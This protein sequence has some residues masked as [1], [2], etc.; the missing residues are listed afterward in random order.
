MKISYG[1]FFLGKNSFIKKSEKSH[2]KRGFSPAFREYSVSVVWKY[3][4][5]IRT[6]GCRSWMC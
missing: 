5:V 1:I 2:K 4:S 3:M 6:G